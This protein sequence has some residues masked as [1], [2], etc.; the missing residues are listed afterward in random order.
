MDRVKTG[1][2]KEIPMKTILALLALS[3][4]AAASAITCYQIFSPGN[5][6]VWQ[7]STPP[8]RL[9]NA[10]IDEQVAKLVPKG[11]LIIVDDKNAPCNPINTTPAG[12]TKRN[13]GEKR[14]DG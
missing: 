5:V 12:A 2:R 1:W 7:G 10:N 8:V 9:D 6:L 13:Q 3:F 11:H 14:T 4:S